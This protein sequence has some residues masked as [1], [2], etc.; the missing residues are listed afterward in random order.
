MANKQLVDDVTKEQ[1]AMTQADVENQDSRT[2]IWQS[3][4]N[5][6]NNAIEESNK[7]YDQNYSAADRAALGR[8]MQRSSYNMQT[9]ANINTAK[10]QAADRL[11]Q[12]LIADY[13]NQ[14]N[15]L[16]Q[17]EY[18]RDFNE[19]Q[20]AENQRQYNE[21]M[22]F[23]QKQWEDQKAQWREEFD[24]NKM[25]SSQQIAY[26]YLMNM[27]ESGDNPSD[28]LLKQA[29]ISR[30]DYNQMKAT[31]A[32]RSA[33]RGSTP[34]PS[35]ENPPPTPGNNDDLFDDELNDKPAAAATTSTTT[36]RIGVS[37]YTPS[38]KEQQQKSQGITQKVK[39]GV[40]PLLKNNN[41]KKVG[42]S[43]T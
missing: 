11:R 24:Y 35:N 33:S 29:G 8:G 36:K 30:A 3:L 10:A 15:T 14:L 13:Q 2:R 43:K 25:T 23:Q 38:Y 12:N 26:N 4:N 5:S 20:F 37:P 16:E 21:N 19:R 6:Y 42:T 31:P 9:L 27:L 22:A 39:S 7:S 17:Q 18:E 40:S 41:L 32:V 1:Q 34:P 28:A